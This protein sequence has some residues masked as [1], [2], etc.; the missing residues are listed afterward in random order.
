MGL[1]D[2][3]KVYHNNVNDTHEANGVFNVVLTGL[4][5]AQHYRKAVFISDELFYMYWRI[6]DDSFCCAVLYV[7]EEEKCCKYKY[8]FTLTTETDDKKISMSF[9]TRCILEDLEEILHSGDCV[10]L[11]YNTILKF[12]NTN[13]HLE[14]E[15]QIN[16]IELDLNFAGEAGGRSTC[17]ESDVHIS[18][19]GRSKRHRKIR[20]HEKDT[21]GSS[22]KLAFVGKPGRCVHGRRF[23]H[24]RSCKYFATF[25]NTQGSSGE[26]CTDSLQSIAPPT[27][28][29]CEPSGHFV[30]NAS[31][32]KSYVGSNVSPS[33]PTEKDLHYDAVG[34]FSSNLS[35]DKEACF[36]KCEYSDIKLSAETNSYSLPSEHISSNLSSDST[37]KCKLCEQTAPKFP[38]SLPEAGWHISS[39]P[40]GTKWKCKMCG[41]IRQ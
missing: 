24:C 32:K 40:A 5:P 23:R 35:T 4:S 22:D 6:K 12:L 11:K 21:S 26:V 30:E 38:N 41:K 9:P 37:W 39:S 31:T 20:R 1:K 33:A 15:F 3:V 14:C 27:G 36:E 13:M 2:H 25:P 28:F 8:K 29:Y 18:L 17:A 7:G 19:F 10:I 34:N 16:A